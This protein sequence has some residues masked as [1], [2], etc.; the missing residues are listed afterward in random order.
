MGSYCGPSN[1][2]MMCVDTPEPHPTEVSVVRP[3]DAISIRLVV[4]RVLSGSEVAVKPYGCGQDA[5]QTFR[6]PG[7]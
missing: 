2:A 1:G 7:P 4:H 5:L 3:G 6:R